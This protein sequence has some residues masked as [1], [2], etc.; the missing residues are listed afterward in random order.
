MFE[1]ISE[2]IRIF[3]SK[4]SGQGFFKYIY[5][6]DIRCVLILRFSRWCYLHHLKLIA[7]ILVMLN[8]FFHGVWVGPR[9]EIGRGLS[10][11][12][13]RGLVINPGTKIGKFCTI[14]HQVTIGGPNVVIGDFVE[15]GAGAKI[16]STKQRAVEV[17]AHSIIGAGAV[18]VKST[19][20]FSI[21][22][23]VPAKIIK[24][25]NLAEWLVDRPYYRDHISIDEIQYLN[26]QDLK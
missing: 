8:D 11:G 17:G 25:K 7:H 6:P 16:I 2:D 26:T 24:K 4:H 14:I 12:H 10:L 9:V 21:M 22:G 20:P 3:R 5:Y 15:I 18:V 23:G 13:P 19:P 1:N